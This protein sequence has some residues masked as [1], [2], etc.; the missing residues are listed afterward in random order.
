MADQAKRPETFRDASRGDF[1]S[2]RQ[3]PFE[4]IYDPTID[5]LKVGSLQR[6]ADATERIAAALEKLAGID[7]VAAEQEG[8]QG[9][10]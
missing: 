2:G 4:Y 9:N 6:L 5:Q 7:P 8:G 10:G 3:T 1:D